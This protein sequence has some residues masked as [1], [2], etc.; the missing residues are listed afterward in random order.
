M[1]RTRRRERDEGFTLIELLVV[2]IIIGVL[3]AIAIPSFLHQRNKGWDVAV[4]SDLRNA[5]IAQDAFLTTGTNAGH[6]AT[7]VLALQ[8][9]G[10]RPSSPAS[11]D[12]GV[13]AMSIRVAPAVGYC[14]TARSRS[15]AYLG[16][17]AI[18]GPV[19]AESPLDQ[20]SCSSV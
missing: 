4:A 13:F 3:A 18:S 20:D 12:G 1:D 2:I 6:Y 19:R 7:T 17:S 11:Y 8:S 5:A 10:F 9:L 14:M 16:Y 15:G